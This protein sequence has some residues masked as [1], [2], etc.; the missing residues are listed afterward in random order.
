MIRKI[1]KRFQVSILLLFLLLVSHCTFGSVGD[2]NSEKLILLQN[3]LSLRNGMKYSFN[4]NLQGYDDQADDD[5]TS[6]SYTTGGNT[7][8]ISLKAES[9]VQWETGIYRINPPDRLFGI[10]SERSTDA[11]DSSQTFTGKTHTPYT[12]PLD[13][14]SDDLYGKSYSFLNPGKNVNFLQNNSVNETGAAYSFTSTKQIPDAPGGVV[15]L[16]GISWEEMY[17]SAT[18]TQGANTWTVQILTGQGNLSL[19]PKCKLKTEGR[20]KPVSIGLQYSNLFRDY[21]ESGSTISFLQRLA[22]LST[23]STIVVTSVSNTNLYTPLIK[24]L[25][26]EDLVLSFPGCIPGVER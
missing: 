19:R 12:V 9:Y 25:N 14:P 22:S 7:Y 3:L 1:Q 2:S 18:I 5:L 20:T 10:L 17:L 6:F 16:A 13:L 21:I 15:S 8:G 4:T 24:N 26:T 11:V 23:A